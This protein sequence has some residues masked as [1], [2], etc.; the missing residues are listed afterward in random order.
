MREILLF[1]IVILIFYKLFVFTKYQEEYYILGGYKTLFLFTIQIP[2][3]VIKKHI[4]A[5]NYTEFDI[6]FFIETIYGFYAKRNRE[7]W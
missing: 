5:I 7:S 4:S 3:L 6:S 2:W 1:D